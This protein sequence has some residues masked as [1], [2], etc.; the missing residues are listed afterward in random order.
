MSK[1]TKPT[2]RPVAKPVTDQEKE[3]QAQ[4]YLANEKKTYF[5]II[6]GG[7]CQN[8]SIARPNKVTVAGPDGISHEQYNIIDIV[9]AALD[10]ADY[11]LE[12]LYNI[13]KS[14]DK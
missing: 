14:E 8:P 10:G 5:Q 7:L 9:D 12:K 11:I 6:L 2:L 3:R 4:I 1:S 13:K